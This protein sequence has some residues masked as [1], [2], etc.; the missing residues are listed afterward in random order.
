MRKYMSHTNIDNF[1][2]FVDLCNVF[3]Q[4]AKVT[5]YIVLY[6]ISY[7]PNIYLNIEKKNNIVKSLSE[8]IVLYFFDL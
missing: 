3:P 5:Y 8:F 7:Y 4:L 6:K 1:L 2:Y